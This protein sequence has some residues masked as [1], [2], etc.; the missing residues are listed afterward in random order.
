MSDEWSSFEPNE[1]EFRL[2]AAFVPKSTPKKKSGKSELEKMF[3]LK[4]R[5][6]RVPHYERELR[7]AQPRMFRF[8]FAWEASMIAVEI[9]GFVILPAQVAGRRMMIAMGGHASP[10]GLKRDIEKHNIATFLGWRVLRFHSHQVKS[11]EAI[12][13]LLRMFAH[14][15]VEMP[16]PAEPKFTE[17]DHHARALR[18]YKPGDNQ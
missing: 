17:A 5:Q 10:D 1:D 3:D 18:D 8:D 12:S 15:K 4:L 2:K 14:Y 9:E 11:G 16:V 6:Y 7:F 13:T